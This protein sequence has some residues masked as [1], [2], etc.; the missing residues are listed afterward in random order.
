MAH[1]RQQLAINS[2]PHCGRANPTLRQ[3]VPIFETQNN[4]GI[5]RWWGVYV[6]N[7][8]GGV[9][10]AYAAKVGGEPQQKPVQEIYP[11][12]QSIDDSIPERPRAYLLEAQNTLHA[13]LA[14]I[15]VSAGAVDAMLQRKRLHRGV[16]IHTD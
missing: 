6:C 11:N 13:P 1:L 7:S 5:K 9:V 2:C 8:C 15:M 3:A 10:T 12:I 4:D 14:A 16:I